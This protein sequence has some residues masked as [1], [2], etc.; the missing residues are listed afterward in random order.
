[1]G[2]IQLLAGTA[3][4]KGAAWAAIVGM[5]TAFVNAIGQLSAS[6]TFTLWAIF[7]VAVDVFVINGLFKYG[8]DRAP[9]R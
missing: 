3:V 4:M 7:A 6:H 9:A 8:G 5:L 1:V 2:V